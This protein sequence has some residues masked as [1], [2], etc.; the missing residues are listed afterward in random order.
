L[1]WYAVGK[2][3]YDA[4][5]AHLNDEELRDFRVQF[6]DTWQLVQT[7]LGTEDGR[8]GKDYYFG[9]LPLARLLQVA[10]ARAFDRRTGP[11]GTKSAGASPDGCSTPHG[12]SVTSSPTPPCRS[13]PA[14]A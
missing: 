2:L 5:F 4:R 8:R 11:A 14:P 3:L 10:F 1:R 12:R 7:V 13:T 9:R 6:G